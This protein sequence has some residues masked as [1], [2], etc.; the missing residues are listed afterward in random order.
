MPVE[1][2]GQTSGKGGRKQ[3]STHV[4]DM[5]EYGLA[6]LVNVNL[7]EAESLDEQFPPADVWKMDTELENSVDR[8]SS[9]VE[10][11]LMPPI[12]KNQGCSY[13]G[14][15]LRQHMRRLATVT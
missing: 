4:V 8:S 10:G 3:S 13:R 5:I 12:D 6:R 9:V 15:C 7:W 2:N 1:C 11:V 14:R